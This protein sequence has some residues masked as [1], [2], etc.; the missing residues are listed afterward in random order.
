MNRMIRAYGLLILLTILAGMELALLVKMNV[1]VGPWDAMALSF[2]FLTGIKMGTVAIICNYL[3]VLG[4]LILLK[5]KFKKINFLQIPISMLLGYSI[6]FF[7]YVVFK[8]MAFN[9][10]IFRITTNI[11]VL[12]SV[13]FTMGA[14]VVLGLPTF[15]LEGFCSAIH[16][17]TGI[18]FAKFRQ[19][20]DFFCVGLVGILTLVFPI[21]WSLREGTIISMILFGPLLGIFMPRIEKLYEKWDLVDGKSQIEKEIEGLE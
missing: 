18:P 2:S 4:Q 3:C 5:K 17:K 6:N 13:A 16:A 15:A 1:G 8:N 12:V 11:I 10:Y 20:V 21:E 14:I 9:N 19:W 7:V